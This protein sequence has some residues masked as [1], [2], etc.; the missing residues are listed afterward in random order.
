MPMLDL[1]LPFNPSMLTRR[2]KHAD[3]SRLLDNFDRMWMQQFLFGIGRVCCLSTDNQASL[4]IRNVVFLLMTFLY[5]LS[6]RLTEAYTEMCEV[7]FDA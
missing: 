4:S 6:V 2:K 3:L 7:R 5:L 1:K